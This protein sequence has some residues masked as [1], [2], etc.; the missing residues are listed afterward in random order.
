LF[1]VSQRILDHLNQSL[2]EKVMIKIQT[3]AQQIHLHTSRTKMHTTRML[4]TRKSGQSWQRLSN[5]LT[6]YIRP[7]QVSFSRILD[8]LVAI[9]K[10]ENEVLKF[11]RDLTPRGTEFEDLHAESKLSSESLNL[12]FFLSFLGAICSFIA[13]NF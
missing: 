6:S 11:E 5:W 4:H 7:F 9:S 10:G 1:L 2:D 13:L 3:T 12:I 8:A